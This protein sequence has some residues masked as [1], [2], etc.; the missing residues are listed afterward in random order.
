M[1]RILLFI[2][3]SIF[4]LKVF[5]QNIHP[6]RL[7]IHGGAGTIKKENMTE[8]KEKGIESIRRSSLC[9]VCSFRKRRKGNGCYTS[10]YSNFGRLSFI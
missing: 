7:V 8:A 6:I 9:G 2:I 3:C 5:A 10:K 4:S 1:K